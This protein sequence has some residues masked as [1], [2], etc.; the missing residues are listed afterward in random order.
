MFYHE[1]NLL[2]IGVSESAY[3]FFYFC[4]SIGMGHEVVGSKGSDDDA[5]SVSK[6]YG[7]FLGFS[8]KYVFDSGGVWFVF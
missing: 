4:G 8:D 1:D 5:S 7:T 3:G 6:E 2:F